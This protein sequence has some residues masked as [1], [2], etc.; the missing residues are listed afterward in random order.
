MLISE[1]LHILYVD[2]LYTID[3]SLKIMSLVRQ[4]KK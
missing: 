4:K 2:L 1:N 3:L